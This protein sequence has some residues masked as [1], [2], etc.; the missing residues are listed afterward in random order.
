MNRKRS[1]GFRLRLEIP[2]ARVAITDSSGF[3]TCIAWMSIHC[4]RIRGGNPYPNDRSR[5]CARNPIIN[6]AV[7]GVN[8][9]AKAIT[10]RSR[11][12]SSSETFSSMLMHFP[13][14]LQT[15]QLSHL[16]I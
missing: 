10:H 13:G 11:V 1:D 8:N 6:R 16:Y 15:P 3:S 9:N 2:Q 7:G 5:N 14:D 12:F 4:R